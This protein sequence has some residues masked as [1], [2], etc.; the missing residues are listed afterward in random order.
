MMLRNSSA[1]E[2]QNFQTF[3]R[4]LVQEIAHTSPL[5]NMLQVY[6]NLRCRKIVG[7][8]NPAEEKKK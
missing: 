2:G 4:I 3:T 7:E 6:K 5:M 8:I 1:K